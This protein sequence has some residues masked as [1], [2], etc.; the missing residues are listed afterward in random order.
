MKSETLSLLC[1]PGTHEP[2]RLVSVPGSDG[3][4]QDTL[5]GVHSGA[6][7][8]VRDGI[9]LLLDESQVSGFNLRY[10]G[11]YN[12]V[13]G[14][15]DVAIKLFA[16]LAGGGE[17]RFRRE[18][19]REL[20]VRDGGPGIPP[21]ERE[22][23]FRSFHTRRPGGSGLGLAIVRTAVERHGGEVRVDEAP[24]G[25]ARFVVSIPQREVG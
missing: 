9:P 18:Y 21:E 12:R 4:V 16:Y 23:V 22:E 14:F 24:E 2:L 3:M 25:G 13:A 20:E 1:A 10:Q 6:R 17:E 8:R 19:L 11:I 5:V 7:F 15:Y